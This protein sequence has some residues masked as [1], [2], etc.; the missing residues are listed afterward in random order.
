MLPKD[1]RSPRLLC[2]TQQWFRHSMTANNPQIT[3]ILLSGTSISHMNKARSNHNTSNELRWQLTDVNL[4]LH[5]AF[6]VVLPCGSQDHISPLGNNHSSSFFVAVSAFSSSWPRKYDGQKK[7][8][9]LSI[10]VKK[11]FPVIELKL[12][13]QK[14]VYGVAEIPVSIQNSGPQQTK[15]M[16][17]KKVNRKCLVL[18]AESL[19]APK[20][21]WKWSYKELRYLFYSHSLLQDGLFLLSDGEILLSLLPSL[22]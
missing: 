8:K 6:S 4:T 22:P 17:D 9:K 14:S 1:S 12:T 10:L 21:Q 11:Y 16:E 7:K 5:S 15:Q 2:R 18:P 20:G 3:G 19:K 13:Q